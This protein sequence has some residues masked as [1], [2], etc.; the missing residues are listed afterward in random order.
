MC[1]SGQVV[2]GLWPD[3]FSELEGVPSAEYINYK[4]LWVVWKCVS[5]QFG[6]LRG[7]RVLFRV[8][9][10]A[11]VHYTNI[12]YGRIPA[13]EQLAVRLDEAEKRA[14]C[15]C[16]AAHI[17][18]RSN[19]VADLGS[20]DSNFARNW[21]ADKF[22]GARLRQDLFD[23]I[24][25]RLRVTFTIDLFSDREGHNALAATWRCP[26][27]TAFEAELNNQTAWAHPPRELIR[28][29][30]EF[31]NQVLAADKAVRVAIL[32]P[33]DVSAPWFRPSLLKNWKRT[34]TWDA[35]S[36]LFR[37]RDDSNNE[38]RWRKGPKSDLKYSVLRSWS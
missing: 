29:T 34:R 31:L 30:F 18:G 6:L 3:R 1:S 23:E 4:E 12:R 5:D 27:L 24:Q 19:R 14:M 15:W 11:A 8:D 10:S 17:P 21:S 38:V 7:W 9:N 20:R 28:S 25:K 32:V 13:L 2:S 37:F 22:R 33:E 16:L 36:D 35:G 26:K